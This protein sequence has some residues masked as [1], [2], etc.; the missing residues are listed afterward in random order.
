M[1]L[2]SN[3]TLERSDIGF[4]VAL[5]YNWH[6]QQRSGIGF[7]V[8]QHVSRCCRMSTTPLDGEWFLLQIYN[9]SHT[10][11]FVVLDGN[12][13]MFISRDLSR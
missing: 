8:E 6:T 9:C 12:I 13:S 10:C 2:L 1:A 7:V 4:I 3:C 11:R 5:L